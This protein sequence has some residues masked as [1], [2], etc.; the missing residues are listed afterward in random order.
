MTTN[1]KLK[2]IGT[3]ED[4]NW[5]EEA[6]QDIRQSRIRQ[7]SW[8]VALRV[9]TLL[10]EKGMSQTDLAEQMKVSRQQVTK[11]VK[12]KE[13][14]TLETIDK[15]EQALGETL[16]DVPSISM[17]ISETDQAKDS[18]VEST[19]LAEARHTGSDWKWCGSTKQLNSI[20]IVYS[21]SANYR[22]YSLAS[23]EYSRMLAEAIAS[24]RAEI[25]ATEERKLEESLCKMS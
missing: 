7:K 19:G 8:K 13:N 24:P 2:K 18:G 20:K 9:L 10:R 4:S 23:V 1:E 17:P 21:G 25:V 11:I 15:L 12:G 6:K 22:D 16:L 3:E 14:L 5:I